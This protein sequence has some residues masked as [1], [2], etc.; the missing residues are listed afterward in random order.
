MKI[1]LLAHISGYVPV[2]A[3]EFAR[4]G[5]MSE[6]RPTFAEIDQATADLSAIS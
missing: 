2:M 5:L 4:K 6:D 1:G 3:I